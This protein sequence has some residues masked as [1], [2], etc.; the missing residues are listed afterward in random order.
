[1]TDTPAPSPPSRSGRGALVVI[2][3][4]S[5]AGKTTLTR[6]LIADD[7]QLRLSVS[8]T[9]RQARPGEIDGEHYYFWDR[10][11]FE[12]E[13]DQG[14]F[15]EHAI[16][17]G[18]LYGTPRAPVERWLSDGLDVVFDIDWQGARQVRSD[19]IA[20]VVSV[21]ILPPSLGVLRERLALRDSDAPDVIESRMARAVDEIGHWRE[22]AYVVLNDNLDE[23]TQA[24][25]TILAAERTGALADAAAWRGANQPDL[26]DFVEALCR[27]TA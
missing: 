15:L 12:V 1:M 6:R 2:S 18:N 11:R 23:A 7:A 25:S 21:F 10:E 13:R 24:L 26:S 16:V 3:S 4:P 27:Q 22:Y 8:A 5:G 17:F 14:A 20:K 19:P 9:T